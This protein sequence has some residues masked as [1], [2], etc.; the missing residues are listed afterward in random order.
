MSPIA[1]ALAPF[2]LFPALVFLFVPAQARRL[3]FVAALLTAMLSYALLRG[4][5]SGAI[6]LI[7][8]AAFGIAAGALLIEAVALLRT[9]IKGKNA[10][11]G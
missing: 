4:S 6:Y 5:P 8:I 1:L 7:P 3:A 9:L 10:A 2:V 11:H